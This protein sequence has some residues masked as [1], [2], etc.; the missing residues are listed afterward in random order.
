MPQPC[1]F[2]T[3]PLIV[4]QSVIVIHPS[5][6]RLTSKGI[7]CPGLYAQGVVSRVPSVLAGH[8][9][10]SSGHRAAIFG[11]G[12]SYCLADTGEICGRRSTAGQRLTIAGFHHITEAAPD[13]PLTSLVVPEEI[14][15]HTGIHTAVNILRE[16][17]RI[18]VALVYY[19]GLL[20]GARGHNPTPLALR[21]E[22]SAI[23]TYT[24]SVVDGDRHD[25]RTN[26][27]PDLALRISG[28]SFDAS[29]NVLLYCQIRL[30]DKQSYRILGIRIRIA[31][32]GPGSHEI[33]IGQADLSGQNFCYT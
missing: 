12:R 4:R 11:R 32:V 14:D 29:V 26:T 21:P 33:D 24:V 1:V 31:V 22:R 30:R 3:T 15:R 6:I 10:G 19:L 18:D 25:R 7:N 16:K 8:L 2:L 13:S 20:L 5:V 28:G 9:P 17:F 23:V 27:V